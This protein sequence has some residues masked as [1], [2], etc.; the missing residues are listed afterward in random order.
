MLGDAGANALGAHA[1]RRRRREPAAAR[2]GSPSWPAI[3]ALTAAS[4][5][6]SFTKVIERTP[7]L[8]W[9]DMLGR[10]PAPA[11]RAAPAGGQPGSSGRRARGPGDRT[12]CRPG[13][14]CQPP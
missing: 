4:E 3:V 10:R 11:R 7:P 14:G 6:V 1:R 8:H 5:K 9:L 2:R 12:A 13:D